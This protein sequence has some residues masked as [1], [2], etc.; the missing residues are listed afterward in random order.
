[1]S[2]KIFMIVTT[3]VL[4]LLKGTY[5]FNRLDTHCKNMSYNTRNYILSD[6]EKAPMLLTDY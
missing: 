1:M 6:E 5:A 4:L 2:H 3:L